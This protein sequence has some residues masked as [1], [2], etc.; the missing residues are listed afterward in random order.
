MSQRKTEKIKS[1]V[2]YTAK[3]D[4][5]MRKMEAAVSLPAVPEPRRRVPLVRTR[6][7]REKNL[8]F[9]CRNWAKPRIVAKMMEP[10]FAD[11]DKECFYVV[12]L[13][14][15]SEPLAIEMVYQGT[16]NACL[17]NHGEVY[18]C[19]LLSGA[20]CIVTLHN[21]PS[22]NPTPSKEDRWMVKAQREA[23]ELLGIQLVDHIIIGSEGK[24]FSF[25]EQNLLWEHLG[26]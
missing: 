9:E 11:L 21:H 20:T 16:A 2:C 3:S 25:R 23:G 26:D 6:L 13:S 12:C 1:D 24:Y 14:S 8:F 5:K 19:A 10:F 17:I 18:K 22:G 7:V 15:K 4:T